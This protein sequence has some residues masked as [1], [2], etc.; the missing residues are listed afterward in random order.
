MPA[1][2]VTTK[3]IRLLFNFSRVNQ[4]TE[5]L[6]LRLRTHMGIKKKLLCL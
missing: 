5:T 3:L 2:L 1:H 6:R 4:F